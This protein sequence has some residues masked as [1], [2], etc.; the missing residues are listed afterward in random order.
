M[1]K[2]SN[3]ASLPGGAGADLDS[4]IIIY[5]EVSRPGLVA[6]LSFVTQ[7]KV[8]RLGPSWS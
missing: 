4:E 5:T 2:F 1:V 3:L 7:D 8:V 6:F